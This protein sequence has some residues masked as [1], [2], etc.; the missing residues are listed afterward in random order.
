M[1]YHLWILNAW[2]AVLTWMKIHENSRWNKD[3]P[4]EILP[5]I[6]HSLWPTRFRGGGKLYHNII[7][8]AQQNP[9]HLLHVGPHHALGIVGKPLISR[10]TSRWF[11]SVWNLWCKSYWI[12]EQFCPKKIQIKTKCFWEIE[13]CSWYYWKALN[14]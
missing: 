3:H 2:M 12:F 5:K 13:A 9:Y 7:F 1:K 6:L 8:C 10:G 11:E 4:C 14:K